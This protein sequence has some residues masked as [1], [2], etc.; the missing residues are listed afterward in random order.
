[1]NDLDETVNCL[2]NRKNERNPTTY[3]AHIAAREGPSFYIEIAEQHLNSAIYCLELD[4]FF[5]YFRLYGSSPNTDSPYTDLRFLPTKNII[6]ISFSWHLFSIEDLRGVFW[7]QYYN[8]ESHEIDVK[9]AFE[10]E[11]LEK[12]KQTLHGQ[13]QLMKSMD[14]G[15]KY[16]AL[17]KFA[18]DQ[19]IEL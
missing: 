18:Q 13:Y 14:E 16:K 5:P 8:K 15:E 10:P 12:M 9:K 1:M 4:Y 2:F 17:E 6:G 3:F 11:F 7:G 19:N